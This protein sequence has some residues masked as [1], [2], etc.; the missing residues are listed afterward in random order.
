MIKAKFIKTHQNAQL[1]KRNNGSTLKDTPDQI[2]NIDE[3]AFGFYT[4]RDNGDSGYDLTAVEDTFIPPTT[5]SLIE[6]QE[7][8]IESKCEVGNAVVPVG[9][10]LAEI[11]DGFWFRIEARSGLGFKHSVQPHFGIIDNQYRGDLGVK[12]YN[13][14]SKGY[15]IKAGDRIAQIV[16]YPIISAD[17][18]FVDVAAESAR[19]E[20]GLGSSG[21]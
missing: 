21:K 7:G 3:G 18:S 19:G 11:Q 2:F 6:T 17:M 9:L 14:S 12:L 4:L 10:K 15:H 13:L 20:N 16:F 1:P 5:V 8:E